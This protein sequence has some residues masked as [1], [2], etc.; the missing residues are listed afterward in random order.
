MELEERFLALPVRHLLRAGT[1]RPATS[2]GVNRKLAEKREPGEI[3]VLSA[4][5]PHWSRAYQ[6]PSKDNKVVTQLLLIG[7]T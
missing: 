7:G 1:G 6:Y 2:G 4:G 3:L 5:T